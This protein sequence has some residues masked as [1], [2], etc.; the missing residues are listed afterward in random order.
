VRAEPY[1]GAAPRPY[2]EGLLPEGMR[3]ERVARELGLDAG[4]TL[5]LLAELGRD[6]VGAVVVLPRG[7]QPPPAPGSPDWLTDAELEELMEI[8]PPRLFDPADEA[9]MRFALPG[10][11][12]KLALVREPGGDRWAWP[13][14][15][16]PSTHVVKPEAGEYPR[17]AVNEVGCTAAL[18]GLGLPV[19]ELE[20]ETIAGRPCA[21]SPRFD[22]DGG[23]PAATRLHQESFWQALGIEPGAERHRDEA[24]RPGFAH[25][26]E[27]LRQVGSEKDVQ[28]LFLVGFCS[29]LL[30]NDADAIVQRRDGH[31]R[32][33]AL[34]LRDGEATPA[35]YCDIASTD[36][37]ESDENTT[38]SIVEWVE[39]TSGYA[40]LMRIG[41]ECNLEALPAVTAAMHMGKELVRNLRL[42]IERAEAEG[43]YEPILDQIVIVTTKRL[44][45]LGE[46]LQAV[47]KGPG[48]ESL[49][50]GMRGEP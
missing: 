14:A 40:G 6:C 49:G 2:F 7:E 41:M 17:F 34:F 19:A 47:V 22:R 36:A 45:R 25:S 46:D 9:R 43:W 32:D 23:G 20:L 27:L 11:R 28:T 39:H 16:L 35:P 18:R 26:A 1:G 37:Y 13:H 21:V 29:F 30:G 44:L 4:D 12:H 5:G 10:E 8:P 42:T 50:E 31:G 15:G 48:G 38:R 24:E 33:A 3:R